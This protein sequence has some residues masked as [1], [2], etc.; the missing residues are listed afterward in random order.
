MNYCPAESY[1]IL[2]GI[3]KTGHYMFKDPGEFGGGKD[4]IQSFKNESKLLY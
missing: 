1:P 4:K 2:I 3:S